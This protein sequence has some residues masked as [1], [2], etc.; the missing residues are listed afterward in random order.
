MT[1]QYI[2]KVDLVGR[3]GQEPE[4]K[5]FESGAAKAQYFSVKVEIG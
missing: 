2:N 3:V 4:I 1:E 5:Y